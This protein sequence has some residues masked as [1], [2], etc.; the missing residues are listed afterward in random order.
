MNIPRAQNH[1]SSVRFVLICVFILILGCNLFST[2]Y[3]VHRLDSEETLPVDTAGNEKEPNTDNTATN[4][5]SF[6]ERCIDTPGTAP[7]PM[8]ACIAG[9]D[10][11]ST[12]YFITSELYGKANP[13]NFSCCAEFIFEPNEN[14][15]LITYE[16]WIN[17]AGDNWIT[18]HYVQNSASQPATCSNYYA[19][20]DGE[21][22]YWKGITEIIVLYANPHCDWIQRDEPG[23][24][25]Y[26][27][28]IAGPC[29]PLD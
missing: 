3:W 8:E 17:E 15:D 26:A 29:A 13:N 28:P 2:E 23:L 19:Q 21:L 27:V 12:K 20:Q 25:A 7:C 5:D 18:H 1:A 14:V 4:D 24:K 9:S 6:G 10:Q 16:H 22:Q 11:Y